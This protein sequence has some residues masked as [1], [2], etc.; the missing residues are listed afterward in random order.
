MI[1][2]GRGIVFAL[3]LF[4]RALGPENFDY[5]SFLERL[6]NFENEPDKSAYEVSDSEFE[7]VKS[8]RRY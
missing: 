6:I 4:V 1:Y 3:S 2:Y 5:S 8:C 7:N